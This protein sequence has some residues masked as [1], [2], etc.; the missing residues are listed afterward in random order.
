[1]ID[2]TSHLEETGR[3]DGYRV[4]QAALFA[5]AGVRATAPDVRTV[6]RLHDPQANEARRE[7]VIHRRT[8]NITEG[9]QLWHMDSELTYASILLLLL[10]LLPLLLSAASLHCWP[11]DVVCCCLLLRCT[12]ALLMLLLDTVS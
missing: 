2:E 8:Y 9:M 4:I 5:R 1:M 6:L 11:A 10:L 12:A 3:A 7:R